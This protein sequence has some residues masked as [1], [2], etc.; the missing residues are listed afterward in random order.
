MPDPRT[1]KRLVPLTAIALVG[2]IAA[3]CG[4]DDSGGGR[5]LSSAD[6]T[7]LRSTLDAVEHDVDAQ[8]CSS[9]D[10]QAGTL[11][12]QAESLTGVSRSLRRAL[13]AS[14]SR[15][16]S[17]V[18]SQCEATPAPTTTQPEGTTGET[19]ATGETGTTGEQN[20]NGDGKKK[21]QKKEKPPKENKPAP[22]EG[23]PPGDEN[24]GGGLAVPGESTPNGGN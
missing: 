24:G 6:A 17:L 12:G 11:R 16:E 22:D 2:A 7:D 15:L 20:G 19:G 5:K 13:V 3:G 23:T 14:A 10:D 18:A 9:A 8:D 1:R 4:S 21:G